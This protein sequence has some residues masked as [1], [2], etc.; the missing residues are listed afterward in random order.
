MTYNIKINCKKAN[1]KKVRAFVG[2]VL[3]QHGVSTKD[4]NLIVVAIDEICSNLIIHS[5][6]CNQEESIEINIQPLSEDF[7]FEIVDYGDGYD[8]SKH[9]SPTM[10]QIIQRKSMGGM[11]LILVKRIMDT[12]QVE[13]RGGANICRLM[14]RFSQSANQA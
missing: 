10:E 13:K 4:A 2:D 1:L 5:H 8:I 12:I 11:G 6:N 3:N 14:K 7:L 9:Q